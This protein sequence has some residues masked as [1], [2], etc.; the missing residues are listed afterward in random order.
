MDFYIKVYHR[1]DDQHA[2]LHTKNNLREDF[3]RQC[4][5]S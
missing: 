4:L 3:V 1:L 2:R 5:V